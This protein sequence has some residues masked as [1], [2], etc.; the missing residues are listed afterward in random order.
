LL[1][2]CLGMALRAK[3]C[4]ELVWPIIQLCTVICEWVNW[5]IVVFDGNKLSTI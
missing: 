2:Y 5:Y 1:M 3:T 4:S